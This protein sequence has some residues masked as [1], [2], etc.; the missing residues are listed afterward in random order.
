[1]DSS[2]FV[3]SF[4]AESGEHAI[5][6]IHPASSN[7]Q[8]FSN[9]FAHGS[10]RLHLGNNYYVTYSCSASPDFARPSSDEAS[11]AEHLA[12]TSQ[13]RKRHVEDLGETLPGAG[14]RQTLATVLEALGEYSKSVQQ[15]KEG[16]KGREIA[17]QL[18]LILESLSQAGQDGEALL[19]LDR[20]VQ[21]LRHQLQGTR[22]F[23]INGATPR[24]LVTEVRKAN[25]KVFSVSSG[26][27]KISLTIKTL[28][29]RA[30]HGGTCVETCSV[31]H[32]QH[33]LRGPSVSAFFREQDTI[34]HVTTISPVVLAYNQVK[35]HAVVF[36]LV[37][38]DALDEFLKLLG[39]GEATIRDCD[40]EGRS[41]LYVS[42]IMLA[43]GAS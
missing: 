23:K 6:P 21:K 34:D 3:T 32:V 8:T 29:S 42:V 10:S 17:A 7:G 5:A 40:V 25:S 24:P 33:A 27:W 38:R 26:H 20:E 11:S 41:L 22:R 16:D 15:L 1:M 43:Y 36:S 30:A 13:K 35:D 4:R 12:R 2:T 9:I 18:R 19:D 28:T 31:L 37:K 39:S 14:S